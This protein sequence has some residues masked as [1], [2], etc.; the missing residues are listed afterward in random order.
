MSEAAPNI[1]SSIALVTAVIL[2]FW[3][4]PLIIRMIK[5]R[6]SADI[7]LAWAFGVWGCLLLMLPQGVTSPDIVW[8]TYTIVNLILFSAVVAT[9]A[10][11]RRK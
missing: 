7:S 3:N 10:L 9:T 5:R 4:I 1:W 2:P 11:L 8:R 6:S